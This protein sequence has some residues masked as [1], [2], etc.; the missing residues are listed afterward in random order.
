MNTVPGT[1][2]GRQTSLEICRIWLWKILNAR[3]RNTEFG[4]VVRKEF[5]KDVELESE[6]IKPLL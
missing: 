6:M 3:L 1:T 2:A 5:L 4:S